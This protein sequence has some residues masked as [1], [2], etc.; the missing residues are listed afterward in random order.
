MRIKKVSAVAILAR[1]LDRPYP[2]I[3]GRALSLDPAEVLARS[4]SSLFTFDSIGPR[5]APRGDVA[6]PEPASAEGPPAKDPSP[7]HNR[8]SNEMFWRVWLDQEDYLFKQALRFSSGNM[9]DAEDA[10]STAKL[11]GSQAYIE[12]EILNE[13]AWLTRL[14]HNA[15]MDQLRNRKRRTKMV[16]DSIRDEPDSLPPLVATPAANPFEELIN[17]E[18]IET[19]ERD[20]LNLPVK[21]LEPLL[22]RCLEDLSYNQIA[23]E[24]NITNAA[25]RKRIQLA[26]ERLRGADD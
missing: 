24:L 22:M 18:L 3:G 13:K 23:E 20:L 6:P 4:L 8:P 5:A 12:G 16:D 9:A 1:S 7:G 17:K 11:N 10:L 26:R 25:A 2:R 21:L 15:C 19:L 14:V